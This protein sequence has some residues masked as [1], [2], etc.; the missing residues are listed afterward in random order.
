MLAK[1]SI[2]TLV[3]KNLLDTWSAYTN[4]KDIIIWNAASIDWHTTEVTIDFQVGG[5]FNF[6]MEAKDG[7]FGFDFCGTYTQIIP[8]QL[9]AYTIDDSRNVIVHFETAEENNTQITIDFE[10]ENQNPLEQ[11]QQGWQAILD[12]FKKH[13]EN[14]A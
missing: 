11:Q 7:S 5:K 2:A 9:I 12:N 4:P 10:A 8:Q 14:K 1:I 13:V 3:K 6:R